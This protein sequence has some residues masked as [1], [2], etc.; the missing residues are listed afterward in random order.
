MKTKFKEWFYKSAV[1]DFQ[2]WQQYILWI[3]VVLHLTLISQYS[4]ILM[5]ILAIIFAHYSFK[6]NQLWKEYYYS[7]ICQHHNIKQ[8][9][10]NL[11]FK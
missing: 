7:L 1:I 8:E 10:K 5:F 3:I 9:T 6:Y 2:N 11:T 4:I